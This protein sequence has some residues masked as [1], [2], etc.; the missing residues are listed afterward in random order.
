VTSA[1]AEVPVAAAPTVR[2][3]ERDAVWTVYAVDPLAAPLVARLKSS[4]AV[5][6]NRLTAMSV[7]VALGAGAVF[8]LGP[9]WIGA[10]LFQL[11]FL[12]D[13]MD[14]KLAALRGERDPSGALHD[15]IGDCLR[16]TG[17]GAGL[18]VGLHTHGDLASS[19]VAAYVGI[20]YAVLTVAEA[21]PV[22]NPRAAISLPARFTSLLRSA[23]RRSAPPG[24]TVDTEAVAFTLGPLIGLPV[25]AVAVAAAVDL[26]HLLM[27]V[28]VAIRAASGRARAR[29]PAASPLH[30]DRR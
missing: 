19:V 7:L 27:Y 23:P 10:L 18:A 8:A 24:T 5:T 22:Q 1:E 12:L 4:R 25:A 6:P 9:L 28:A 3:K 11:S 26:L 14:G 21:R 13:C 17:A 16:F 2:V 30:S 29:T 15:T 20:R